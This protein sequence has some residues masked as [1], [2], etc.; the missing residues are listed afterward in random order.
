MAEFDE[1]LI[2][3]VRDCP[4]LYNSQS[5]DF[6]INWKKENAWQTIANNMKTSGEQSIHLALLVY[7]YIYI[8]QLRMFKEGGKLCVKD[9]LKNT[10]GE[11]LLVQERMM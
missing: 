7:S 2:N 4:C 1:A 5:A 3:Y 9:L 8:I 6:K 11:I 10:K